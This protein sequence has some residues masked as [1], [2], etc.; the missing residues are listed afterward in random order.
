[1]GEA[2][3]AHPADDAS[4]DSLLAALRERTFESRLEP[5][6]V[7]V[8]GVTAARASI[9]AQLVAAHPHGPVEVRGRG[10]ARI[11]GALT[12]AGTPQ[13]RVQ[14]HPANAD[15]EV[16]FVGYGNSAAPPHVP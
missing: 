12:R 13:E 7:V 14:S 2:R 5:R 15:L 3:R 6:G 16:V 10:A 1:M 8:E 4:R 9:L 11:A